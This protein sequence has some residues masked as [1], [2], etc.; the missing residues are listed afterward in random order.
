VPTAD[1]FGNTSES[2]DTHGGGDVGL[3]AIGTWSQRVD[4]LMEQNVIDHIF[5]YASGWRTP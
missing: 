5:T 3:Y 4:G 1:H 2:A